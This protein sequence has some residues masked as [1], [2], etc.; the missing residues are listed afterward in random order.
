MSLIAVPTSGRQK[1]GGEG[2]LHVGRAA[3]PIKP[4]FVLQLIGVGC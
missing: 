3:G 1:P 2:T 4:T